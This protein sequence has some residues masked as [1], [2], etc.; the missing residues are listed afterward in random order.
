MRKILST[1]LFFSW[2]AARQPLIYFYVLPFDNVKADPAVEWIASGLTDMVREKFK[3]EIGLK[4]QTKED[5]E[6]IMNDRSLMLKQPRGSR[7]FLLL[8]KYSRQLDQINVLM[9]LI[10]I[11]TWEEL[12]VRTVNAIYS[13]ITVLNNQVTETIHTMLFP[14]V[15]KR[16]DLSAPI[17][18]DFL[19][20]KPAKRRHPVSV[21]S[22]MVAKNL[23]KELKALEESMD[24]LFGA[25]QDK[26]VKPKKDVTR[27]EKGEWA[28]DFSAHERVDENPELA[29]N[30]QMLTTVIERLITNPYDI[31]MEKPKFIYHPDDDQYMTVQFHVVY[32]LKDEIIKEMLN[33]LPYTGLEQNGTLTIFYFSRESFNFPENITET[34]KSGDYR[35]V[36][37]I[38]FFNTEKNPIV[39]LADTPEEQWHSRSS[40]KVLYIPE[41]QFTPLIEFTVGGWSLQVAMETVDLYATY[42]FTLPMSDVES[43]SN[44]SIKFVNENELKSFLDPIL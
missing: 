26:E 1:I 17:I 23:D 16:T 31:R 19:D 15:P 43:L 12:D 2:L 27:F 29:P 35:S 14:F 4:L 22:E 10:D 30:T 3:N 44:V 7:N 25:K 24:V 6:I 36:P 20:P 33:T 21:R 34:I 18:P 8:G 40:Q 28:M 41:R 42:E 9:Q 5:L 32:S 37:V 13:D 39:V 11:A 38:R